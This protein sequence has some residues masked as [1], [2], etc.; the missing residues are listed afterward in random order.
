MLCVFS[1]AAK[2]LPCNENTRAEIDKLI[3]KVNPIGNSK[4]VFPETIPEAKR[5]CK[6]LLKP[7]TTLDDLNKRCVKGMLKEVVGIVLYSIK[8]K[9]RAM[10]K[11]STTLE[12][13]ELVDSGKCVNGGRMELERCANKSLDRFMAMRDQPNDMKIPLAC[14]EITIAK[15]CM[16]DALSRVNACNNKHEDTLV[17]HFHGLSGGAL[18]I[19]CNEFKE[20]SD[21]CNKLKDLKLNVKTSR[22]RSD[23]LVMAVMQLF[24]SLDKK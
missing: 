22:R 14:C 15:R 9:R 5:H 1:E 7:I 3:S 23:S 16:L 2:Q 8:K 21:R 11:K 18:K 13:R 12:L 6:T 20:N 17:G 24:E 10:C 19:A 4:M